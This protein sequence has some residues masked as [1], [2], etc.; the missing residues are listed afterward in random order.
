MVQP[1]DWYHVI[2][3]Q[4][5]RHLRNQRISSNKPEKI[6]IPPCAQGIVNFPD[7]LV[8]HSSFL[9]HCTPTENS[10][11][12]QLSA[13][14]GESS[15][16]VCERSETQIARDVAQHPLENIFLDNTILSESTQHSKHR[17]GEKTHC[18]IVQMSVR[19]LNHKRSIRLCGFGFPPS[20]GR[21]HHACPNPVPPRR[22]G[23]ESVPT[24][25]ILNTPLS[26]RDYWPTLQNKI[27]KS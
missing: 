24:R 3:V 21:R 26:D 12:R 9:Q 7:L 2:K 22:L 6:Q 4:K 15:F 27:I 10:Q 18:K 14:L 1:I 8:H 13:A 23:L 19:S 20:R 25:P 17:N 5:L 11:I 16:Q